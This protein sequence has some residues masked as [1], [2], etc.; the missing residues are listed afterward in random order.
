MILYIALVLA[1]AAA[2]IQAAPPGVPVIDWADRNYALVEVSA[3]ATAYERLVKRNE[4]VD[5]T[6]SWNVYSGDQGDT[7]YVLFD[8]R[9]VWRGE[10]AAKRASVPVSE[11]GKHELVVKLCNADGCSVSK[12]VAVKIADTDGAHLDPLV[13][14]WRENNRPFADPIA[15]DKTV[16][17]YFVE[18]GVYGRNFAAD[19]VPVPNLTHLLYGFVPLCGGDGINDSLKTITGSFEAL[20][21]SCAGRDD[22]KLTLHDPW[23]ALQ[24]A[25][26]GVSA[27][28]EPYKGNFGQLM[29]IKKA[30]PHL[31]VLPSIGGWTLS[32][33]FYYLHDADKRRVF[34]DSAREFLQTWKFFDGLDVDWEFP[35]GKGAN[36]L[37][38][39]AERD[40][41]TY[42]LL[43]AELRAMLD[44]LQA[45]TNRTY[46]LTS[47]IGAGDDKIA[48]VDYAI[49]HRSLDRIF[50]MTYDFKGAWS[51]SD[52]GHQTGLYAPA[53]RPDERYT[54]DFAVQRLLE[55]Q[56]P[57]AKIVLGVAM[58]G[59]GWTGVR[60]YSDDN[61]FTG[62]AAGPVAGT[63]ED[64]VVDYRRIV[65]DTRYTHHYDATAKAAYA[66][67]AATGDL[68]S[69]DNVRSVLDK[70]V[71]VQEHNLGGLFAWEI[72]AD[73]GDLLNSMQKGL[74]K[75]LFN[76]K[77]EL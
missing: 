56:V 69:F 44:D 13:Y 51:Y 75:G 73:N 45:R 54:A 42:T 17:A 76:V 8:D 37:L 40:R 41:D 49:A 1:V 39:D 18:W 3:D 60:D 21:Q 57:P 58:Y 24:K 52:L 27:W 10:A 25:Q 70:A 31:R 23:A 11:G 2:C 72:D 6:V 53:W 19:K 30:Y 65:L 7:A 34:V 20:Q 63:W 43:L 55:Q 71:Y 15:S 9:P 50:L 12:P 14:A 32:D 4:H 26:K 22:F 77:L 28:N 35:G 66:F 16:A 48:A 29:A 59:R 36:P 64:G 62:V 68:I 38:G 5:V 61:P 46:E 74:R 47:A 67:A 33:P